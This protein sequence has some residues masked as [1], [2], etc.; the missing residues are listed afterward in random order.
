[1]LKE[2]ISAVT[3]HKEDNLLTRKSAIPPIVN[4]STKRII[5][6][7]IY[8]T[9][10]SNDYNDHHVEWFNQAVIFFVD[11]CLRELERPDLFTERKNNIDKS[12]YKENP[13]KTH[14]NH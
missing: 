14:I 13:G 8:D 5:T 3:L 10:V 7:D 2:K 11:Q 4:T 6:I 9:L 1:M 12:K